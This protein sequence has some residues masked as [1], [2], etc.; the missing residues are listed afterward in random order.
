MQGAV[1]LRRG[2]GE[3]ADEFTRADKKKL[4]LSGGFG[5][6]RKRDSCRSCRSGALSATTSGTTAAARTPW[7]P[8]SPRSP[9]PTG[10][11][12]PPVPR[13]SRRTPRSS[14]GRGAA[15]QTAAR[16]W[17]HVAAIARP[18]RTRRARRPGGQRKACDACCSDSEDVPAGAQLGNSL[19][20]PVT[21]DSRVGDMDVTTLWWCQSGGG[22]ER[23]G[24]GAG[25][26][27]TRAVPLVRMAPA[28][29]PL[30]C[31]STKPG[32]A[33]SIARRYRSAM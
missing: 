10:R 16:T 11:T 27:P 19:E 3:E 8:T 14:P 6:G 26:C 12:R 22:G 15:R 28:Q 2:R 9:T 5:P 18:G 17:L 23:A 25:G 33:S 7:P 31:S 21:G 24:R 4:I 29:A 1:G 20:S 30:K 32:L 13:T